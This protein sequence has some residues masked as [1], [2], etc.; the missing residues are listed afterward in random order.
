MSA[1][2]DPAAIFRS[3]ARIYS[4]RLDI[5]LGTAFGGGPAMRSSGRLFAAV[6]A[7]ELIVRLPPE[8]CMQLVDAGEGRLYVDED[9]TTHEDWLVVAGDDAAEW[10][11]YVTEALGCARD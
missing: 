8:R 9:G 10:E 1:P 2:E 5:T 6:P 3:L 4:G 11:G 7:D